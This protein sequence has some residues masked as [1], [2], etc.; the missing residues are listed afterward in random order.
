MKTASTVKSALSRRAFL[1]LTAGGVGVATLAACVAPA[2]A[3]AAGGNAPAAA[4]PSSSTFDAK[5]CYQPTAAD[6]KTVKFPAKQGP[7]VIALSN[8]YIGNVW[9]TQM[10]KMA[11]AF[12]ELP[13]IKPQIKQFIVNSSGESADTEISQIENMIAAGAQ[14]IIVNA[15]SPTALNPVIKKAQD[16]GVIVVSFD[17]IVTAPNVVLVNEDQVDFGRKMA[18][19]LVDAIGSKGN[20]IMVTGVDG[21]S[22]NADRNKGAHEVFDKHADIKVVAEVNGK[23]DPG[24]AQQVTTA[25][26]ASAPDIA[27]IW[28]QG[29]TDG[30]VRALQQAGRPLVPI[31]GEAE[32]GFRKQMV[33]L[34]DKGLKGISI[35]QTP[36]MVCVSIKAALDLLAGNELPLSIAMPLPIAKSEDLKDGVNVF[37]NGPDNFFTPIQIPACGVNLTFDQINAQQL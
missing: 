13:D 2:A 4:A 14:A 30:V 23:W 19:W 3:P 21:T 11:K 27:G 29:G 33:Q 28:C 17:N 25:A 34:K 31:A 32:N 9:R 37:M 5:A 18:E 22:V 16:A 36:G 1:R 8:S 12:V 20:V 24:T 7:Y 6:T 15:I 26:L 35:G 10:I